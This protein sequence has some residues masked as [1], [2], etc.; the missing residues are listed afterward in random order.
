M[1]NLKV[2]DRHCVG[3]E[4]HESEEEFVDAEAGS[5]ASSPKKAV[6]QSAGVEDVVSG[7]EVQ[8]SVNETRSISPECVAIPAAPQDGELNG[9]KHS[10]IIHK[11]NS[12]HNSEFVPETICMKMNAPMEGE[13][14][15]EKV[16]SESSEENNTNEVN[17]LT[18]SSC[19]IKVESVSADS[20]ATTADDNL[21]DD[22]F[23]D[24][25][26]AKPEKLEIKKDS[27]NYVRALTPD[28]PSQRPLS[29][30]M[31]RHENASTCTTSS[32][33]NVGVAKSNVDIVVDED[34]KQLWDAQEKDAKLHPDLNHLGESME[35]DKNSALWSSY[36]DMSSTREYDSHS[37][38]SEAKDIINPL[39]L[40]PQWGRKDRRPS[41]GVV[42]AT[43]DF[44]YAYDMAL[45]V[46]MKISDK[47]IKALLKTRLV[48]FK[49]NGRGPVPVLTCCY[50]NYQI[51]GLSWYHTI[52][53][54]L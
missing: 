54:G 53:V 39:L 28:D 52:H 47:P 40:G 49:H 11:E 31:E 1:D 7:D 18:P 3:D 30:I 43:S 50:I 35:T 34:S 46:K 36:E 33:Q 24:D 45:L 23:Q 37:A 4:N 13:V 2:P 26:K 17:N 15:A 9:P 25:S 8:T 21:S 5:A 6:K 29:P 10:E 48:F 51:L 32:Y 44:P 38:P 42:S 22:V 14:V 27:L 41:S 19:Q 16:R 12:S 20:G